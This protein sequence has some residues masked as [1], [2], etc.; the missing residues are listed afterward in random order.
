MLKDKLE[1]KLESMDILNDVL[2]RF[3]SL[4]KPEL[5]AQCNDALF[6]QLASTRA[7]TRKRAISCIAALS[8]ALS[9]KLLSQLVGSIVE[10]MKMPAVDLDL[11]RTYI[12]TLSAISRSGGY[13]L[14]R[15]LEL[16]MPLVLQQC[17]PGS[18]APGAS[19]PE[20]IES[21]LQ[22]FESFVSR[23]PAEVGAYEEPIAKASLHYL[24][25]D[26]NYA[27]D[28]EMEE[29]DNDEEEEEMEDDEDDEN[30]SDDDDV[31][32]K[33]RRAAAKVL[34]AAL[35]SRPDKLAAMVP[36]V[37]PTLISRF[38]EREE[39]VKMDVFATFNVLLEQVGIANRA[40]SEAAA[41]DAMVVD[42]EGGGAV[43]PAATALLAELPRLIKAL[44]RQL[45]EKAVRTR[46]AAFNCLRQL[47]S[48]LP[49][50]LGEHA[51]SLVPGVVRA[52]KDASANPLRIE[53][54][55]FLQLALSTHPPAVFQPHAATLVP[56]VLS[57]VEDRYY[58]ITAEALSA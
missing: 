24:R 33:V 27:D 5:S 9:D 19:D 12:Q 25:F 53:A 54:L 4:L 23:C 6:A 10:R 41:A 21:C 28:D 8:A 35:V 29:D 26:P 20:M 40:A 42:G 16:V 51:S 11:G 18:S 3:G 47:A 22:A 38:R 37:A 32:W 56:T 1:V 44:S 2:R 14:G 31:S 7:A 50:C 39:N 43:S 46:T 13:R 15:Q 34:S 55:A 58:K 45:Q 57:L 49:G 48:S 30:Y 17:E 36:R 52:L